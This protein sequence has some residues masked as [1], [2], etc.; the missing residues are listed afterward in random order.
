MLACDFL[1]VETVGVTR[2]YVV[3]AELDPRRVHLA[4]NTAHPTDA[5]V[6]Q[7]ARNMLMDIDDQVD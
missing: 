5:R 7:A 3:I 6:T 1:T 2:L 4:G